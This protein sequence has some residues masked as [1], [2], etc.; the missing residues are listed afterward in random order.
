MRI[1]FSLEIA[2]GS[3]FNPGMNCAK[4][5]VRY[6]AFGLLLLVCLVGSLACQSLQYASIDG[7]GMDRVQLD[8]ELEDFIRVRGSLDPSEDVFFY[9]TG[10]IFL[11]ETPAKDAEPQGKFRK[12]FLRLEGVNIA[13]FMAKDGGIRMLSREVA[14]Y[15]DADGEPVDCLLV[16]WL[17]DPIAVMHIANDPVNFTLSAPPSHSLGGMKVFVVNAS[18]DYASP[19]NDLDD[20]MLFGGKTYQSTELFQFYAPEAEL[21]QDM[22]STSAWMSWSRVG[23]P[24]PWM[25]NPPT[26]NRSLIYHTR[27]Y[28]VRGG[29][30]ALPE[31]LR[32]RIAQRHPEFVRAPTTE[33]AGA[34]NQTSWTA[35]KQRLSEGDYVQTCQI[36]TE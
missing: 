14:Y 10:E 21:Q 19:L 23:Q 26:L 20:V 33:V 18:M 16:D 12:P 7:D 29:Y 15:L 32:R 30:E 24:L 6:G 31:R 25:R 35:F 27:G 17:D 34:K 4:C 8:S 28:K 22:D 13:R 1:Y 9:F 5:T 3:R 2:W 36:P 11:V